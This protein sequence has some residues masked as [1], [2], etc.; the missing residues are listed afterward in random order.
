M[1]RAAKQTGATP[2]TPP[3]VIE[4]F[5]ATTP[6]ATAVPATPV[7]R[8][9]VGPVVTTPVATVGM[10]VSATAVATEDLAGGTGAEDTAVSKQ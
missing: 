1:I 10:V 8:A 2:V 3:A 9:M 7:D 6:P 4:T 5:R